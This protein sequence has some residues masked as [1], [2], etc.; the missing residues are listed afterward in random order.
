MTGI[1][2]VKPAAPLLGAS[3]ALKVGAAL[4]T[5]PSRRPPPAVADALKGHMWPRPLRDCSTH[6]HG[7]NP[8]GGDAG[9]REGAKR[10]PASR[11]RRRR[12][13]SGVGGSAFPLRRSFPGHSPRTAA[14]P[15]VPWSLPSLPRRSAKMQLRQTRQAGSRSGLPALA[16]CTA[17]PQPPPPSSLAHM[18]ALLP[19]TTAWPAPAPPAC[20]R[21]PRCARDSELRAPQR[22]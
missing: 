17:A 12:R 16:R 9:C 6:Y 20:A 21:H 3:A 18:H 22:L 4:R 14:L 13:H 5:C 11:R 19:P 1:L 10:A 8:T 2:R 15:R 7:T